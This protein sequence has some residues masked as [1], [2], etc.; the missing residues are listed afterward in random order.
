MVWYGG[1]KDQDDD[2]DDDNEDD[3]DDDDIEDYDD[4]D[5]DD[6]D[7]DIFS[8]SHLCGHLPGC[9]ERLPETPH[10]FPQT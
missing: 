10:R 7:D 1:N 9:I 8:M 4:D 2:K 3:D 5:I 6:Q